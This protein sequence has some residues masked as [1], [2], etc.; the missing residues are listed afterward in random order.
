MRQRVAQRR[1]VGVRSAAVGSV[2]ALAAGLA[3]VGGTAGQAAA[4]PAAAGA[5]A[6][7]SCGDTARDAATASSVNAANAVAADAPALGAVGK[8]AERF[9]HSLPAQAPIGLWTNS[10]LTL[11]TP[12]SK[13]TVRLDVDSHG[14]STASLMVQRYEPRTHRWIDLDTTPGDE[15]NPTHGVF[16]FP[17]TA[18]ASADHP[19]TV[20]LRYQ[21]LDRP[22]TFT[23]T[24]SVDDGKGRTH[25]AAART[26]TATR[27]AVSVSGWKSGTALTRGGGAGEFTLTVKNTTDRAYPRL[28]ASYFAYGAGNAHALTPKDLVLQQYL[29]GRGWER[30]ALVGGGCDPGMSAKLRP[31]VKGP[32]APGASA[33]YRLRVAVAASAP[34]DVTSADAGVSAGNG[35]LS[36]FSRSLPFAIKGGK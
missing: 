29:P 3:L 2:L 28:F 24:P 34:R 23:V 19:H 8:A 35:D 20:A 25:R 36:F 16:T 14:F 26:T 10:S 30:V 27:P 11:R 15:S 7:E 9:S 22:G 21:D 33:A 12:V 4:I 6:V 5:K 31:V 17:L 32:L 13:G 18:A 1:S